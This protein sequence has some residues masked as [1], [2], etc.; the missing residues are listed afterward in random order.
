MAVQERYGIVLITMRHSFTM[1]TL[2][3]KII[4]RKCIGK[5]G[6]ILMHFKD[7]LYLIAKTAYLLQIKVKNERI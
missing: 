2:Q 6:K 7:T 1:L 3:S 4:F 5:Q